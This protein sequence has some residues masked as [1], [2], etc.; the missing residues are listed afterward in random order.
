MKKTIMKRH[1]RG[2]TDYKSRM[3]MLKS[4]LNRIAIRKTNKY[5][6]VQLIKSKEARD[7]VIIGIT[8]KELL[9]HGWDKKFSGSLKSIPAAYL[10]GKL[11]GKK[12]LEKEKKNI[13][14][15]TGLQRYVS[16]SRIY[17][18]LKGLA[19][20][21]VD[22]SYNEKVFPSDDRIKGNHLKENVQKIIAEVEKKI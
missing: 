17:A 14:L 2:K 15:D 3:I 5:I 4:G 18:V 11:M 13:I 1:R 6:I 21:G 19:D 9:K 7:K 10:T 22:I 8:S 16:G 20:A 12:I